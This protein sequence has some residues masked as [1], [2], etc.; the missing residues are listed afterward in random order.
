MEHN[1]SILRPSGYPLCPKNWIQY[2]WVQLTSFMW[3]LFR[4]SYFIPPP[5][6]VLLQDMLALR[7]YPFKVLH[8]RLLWIV[9]S[10]CPYLYTGI[11]GFV[12]VN[13][14]NNKWREL[15]V[16]LKDWM[17]RNEWIAILWRI[18]N[19]K[20]CLSFILSSDS[21]V[22][23]QVENWYG[24]GNWTEVDVRKCMDGYTDGCMMRVMFIL[25]LFWDTDLVF[26]GIWIIW[27]NSSTFHV[28]LENSLLLHT[29]KFSN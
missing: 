26:L 6:F 29:Y 8:S 21:G 12:S 5:S 19:N 11:S 18:A 20:N 22:Q 17:V 9:F 16:W 28:P 2:A 4:D 14:L 25:H 24:C 1:S 10:L 3:L 23:L 7:S 13:I 27:S 15:E